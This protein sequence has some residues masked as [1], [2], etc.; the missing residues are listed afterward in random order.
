VK[1]LSTLLN[2]T[3]NNI[4]LFCNLRDDARQKEQP[5]PQLHVLQLLDSHSFIHF[6]VGSQLE[7]RVPI[8]VSVITYIIRH[9]VGPSGR[10]I[11]P[12]QRPL[13]TQDNTSYKHNRQTSKPRA[14]FEPAI[15]ATK[16]SQTYA[17]DR[18][19]TEIGSIRVYLWETV[20]TPRGFSSVATL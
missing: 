10:V 11:S 19:T 2:F 12:S 20:V 13:P 5:L 16:R 1:S 15:P 17:L 6:P 4:F 3:L 14:R 8:G 18:P 9:A 7:Q